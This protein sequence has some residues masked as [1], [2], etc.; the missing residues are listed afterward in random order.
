[1][2]RS[3]KEIQIRL[4]R[5]EMSGFFIFSA[6]FLQ[7]KNGMSE[8]VKG[9]KYFLRRPMYHCLLILAGLIE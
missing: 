9:R 4:S 7:K 5:S 6:Y 8:C 1:M 2:I 3:N